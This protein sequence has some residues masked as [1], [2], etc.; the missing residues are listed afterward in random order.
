MNNASRD[1]V[2]SAA[3][4]GERVDLETLGAALG[5]D[6]GRRSL[7]AFVLLRAATVADDIVP[8]EHDGAATAIAIRRF[9]PPSAGTAVRAALAASIV[10]AAVVASFLLGTG[11]RAANVALTLTAPPATV[12]VTSPGPVILTAPPLET[13]DARG[14]SVRAIG[15]IAAH[16]PTPTRVLRFV[17]GVDWTSAAE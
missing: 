10:V 15:R 1:E 5:T 14:A 9:G 6:E 12:M 4:D 3:L 11:F 17:P 13:R 8:R 7:A 2:I 16:P